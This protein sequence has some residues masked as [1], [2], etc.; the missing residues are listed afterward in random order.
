M[1]T[2]IWQAPFPIAKHLAWCKQLQRKKKGHAEVTTI[3]ATT[4]STS[5]IHQDTLNTKLKCGK[6]GYSHNKNSVEDQEGSPT[7]INGTFGAKE[8]NPGQVYKA[9]RDTKATLATG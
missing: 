7:R 2:Q 6:Y 8:V 4:A 5:S 1:N 9:E 3:I